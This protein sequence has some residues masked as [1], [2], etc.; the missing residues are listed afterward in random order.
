MIDFTVWH[1]EIQLVEMTGHLDPVDGCTCEDCVTARR[2]GLGNTPDL[3]G[4]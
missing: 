2:L 1:D 4:R 3:R